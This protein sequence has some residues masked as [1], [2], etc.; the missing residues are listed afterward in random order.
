MG[1]YHTP[2]GMDPHIPVLTDRVDFIDT[3]LDNDDN[4]FVATQDK[5]VGKTPQKNNTGFSWRIFRWSVFLVLLS[6]LGAAAWYE[7]ETSSLQ[8]RYIPPYAQRLT[9]ELVS[10]PNHGQV[11]YPVQGPF[12]ERLGYVR[13]PAMLNTLQKNGLE[14]EYQAR[15]S[16]DLQRYVEQGF[17][18]PFREKTITG[19]TLLDGDRFNFY[20]FQYPRRVFASFEEIPSLMVNALLFIENRHLLDPA[21]VKVNPAIDWGRFIKAAVFKLGDLIDLNLPS[22]GGSTL[23]TQIEKYRHSEDG[24]TGSISEKLRQM[25]SASVRVY[26]QGE[27]TSAARRRLVLDYLNTVPLSAAPGFG[28]VNGIGDGL[29]VWFGADFENVKRLLAMRTDADGY[30]QERALALRQSISLMIAHRRPSYYLSKHRQELA[31]T[32]DAY[33]R[34][35]ARNNE[36]SPALKEAALAQHVVFRDFQVNPAFIPAETNKGV[37]V[38]RNRLVSMLNVP[39]YDLDRMDLTVQATLQKD[40]QEKAT[41]YLR[42]L[43]E[44]KTAIDL[45]LVGE[46]LLKPGQ[47]DDI[48]Y[49]F[50]LFERTSEGNQ[51]RVQTDNTEVP[52]DINEGS[53][54]ELGS[55][56]KLRVLA[57]YLTVIAELHERIKTQGLTSVSADGVAN[58]PLSR[59]TLEKMSAQPDMSLPDL[60]QAALDKTYSASPAEVFFTGGGVHTFNNFKRED[61]GRVPTVRESL[62]ESINLPF[63]RMLRDV[64][65]YITRQQWSDVNTVLKDDKDPR[66]QEVLSRFIDREGSLLLSRFWLKYKNKTEQERLEILLSGLKLTPTRAAVIHRYLFPE[67]DEAQFAAFMRENLKEQPLSAKSLGTLYQRYARQQFNLQDQGYLARVHPLELW[68]LGFMQKEPQPTLARILAESKDERQAVY[69][70][71]MK[72]RAK[73]ARDTRIRT[74]LEVEAFT[75]LHRRW[76]QLGYPFDHLVPSLASAL[77]SSGDRP[78]A[79]A[80]LMGIILNGGERLPVRRIRSL[81]FAETTPYEVKVAYPPVE[82]T[83]VMHPDVAYAMKMALAD[84]VN[85]GTARRLQDAYHHADGS[86]LLMGGKTGT[87]DNRLVVGSGGSK[88]KARALSR[89]AT[90]VFYLGERHFG[91]LTAFVP[92]SE[93]K[94]FRF[95][96]ALPAQVLKGMA[97][98]LEPYLHEAESLSE[99]ADQSALDRPAPLADTE[100][101]QATAME[102][103]DSEAAAAMRVEDPNNKATP[104]GTQ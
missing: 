59:W 81:T 88:S 77:G 76:K 41:A 30:I 101:T 98:V 26:Q 10:G 79:L 82:A 13:L 97:P 47:S 5:P 89:T 61:N 60:L 74:T 45:G 9:Y 84:V 18:P 33:I 56:A 37:N 63:V 52:F 8:S 20:Q 75:E 46:Y 70:W 32:T 49:S 57:S 43:R 78:A 95:T 44:E 42:S 68:L 14:V 28:E 62:Q 69:V 16:A 85:K 67:A 27:D 6:A 65:S 48:R 3:S 22:M 40:I 34:L 73:N 2:V 58:D 96:S 36:I 99:W 39:L 53:K 15:F 17:Y 64:I 23:A 54:L 72:T 94:N 38:V 91:T 80:E 4:F 12:D 51:V 50:T 87:G 92:G 7:S 93:A 21:S 71:L 86:P 25:A 55:T 11:I 35:L 31:A 29:F 104:T 90:L 1:S 66:R 102:S 19:L 83:A 100:E 103:K 24:V